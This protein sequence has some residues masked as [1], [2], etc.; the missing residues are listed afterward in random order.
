MDSRYYSES[1]LNWRCGDGLFFKA[2]PL[3]SYALLTTLHPLL[4]KVLQTVC[5]KLLEDSGTGGFYLL[6]TSKF[7]AS[8]FP[9]HGWES[10][11]IARM[12]CRVSDP[13]LPS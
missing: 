1:E 9:L 10:P 8:K 12:N 2:P 11:E 13:L 3:A 5:L 4:E 7:L 6:I